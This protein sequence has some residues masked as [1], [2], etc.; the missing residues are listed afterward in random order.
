LIFKDDSFGAGVQARKGRGVEKAERECD[1]LRVT[2]ARGLKL[3]WRPSGAPDITKLSFTQ[4]RVVAGFVLCCA[5]QVPVFDSSAEQ[6][7]RTVFLV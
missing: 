5:W 2:L 6:L 7:C 4:D 3:A 1:F